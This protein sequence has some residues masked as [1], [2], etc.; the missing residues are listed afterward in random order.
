MKFNFNY[1]FQNYYLY[2][3]ITFIHLKFKRSTS[4]KRFV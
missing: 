3:E 1:T 2:V 4:E